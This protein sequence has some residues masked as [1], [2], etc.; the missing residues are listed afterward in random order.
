MLN[1]F[2]KLNKYKEQQIH[3]RK[4]NLTNLL[5]FNKNPY[6]TYF[7]YYNFIYKPGLLIKLIIPP[8]YKST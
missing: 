6:K 7:N 1:N 3:K 5:H 4:T 8:L 2:R